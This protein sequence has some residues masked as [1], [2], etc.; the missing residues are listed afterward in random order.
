MPKS[1]PTYDAGVRSPPAR[2][3][4]PGRRR[5]EEQQADRDASEDR[6]LET[7]N[8]RPGPPRT[9][10]NRGSRRPS[11]PTTRRQ[12]PAA[13][14]TRRTRRCRPSRRCGTGFGTRSPFGA[15]QRRRVHQ[16]C[17]V[18]CP[19]PSR[20]RHRSM[21]RFTIP[22]IYPGTAVRTAHETPLLTACVRSSIHAIRES[23][24]GDARTRA[25]SRRRAF[26]PCR[27]PSLASSRN[28]RSPIPVDSGSRR[29]EAARAT[30]RRRCLGVTPFGAILMTVP[31]P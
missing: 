25:S 24:P 16:Q 26:A 14:P 15:R 20:E 12:R 17:A 28:P 19:C 4:E 21:A 18:S 8:P 22:P 1:A 2:W 5:D 6:R 11:T 31:I 7:A 30:R 3:T 23:C 27:F 29:P 9:P 10:A 13:R